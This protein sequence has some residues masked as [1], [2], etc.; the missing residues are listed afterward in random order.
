VLQIIQCDEGRIRDEAQVRK[1]DFS[2]RE[3]FSLLS[4]RISCNALTT[5][6]EKSVCSCCAQNR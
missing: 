2:S 1:K 5:A 6:R 4:R 3:R